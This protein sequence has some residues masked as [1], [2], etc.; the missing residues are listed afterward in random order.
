MDLS[1]EANRQ[2][3][4][5]FIRKE[6]RRVLGL[7]I[8]LVV[9]VLILLNAIRIAPRVLANGVPLPILVLGV[10]VDLVMAFGTL[11]LLRKTYKKLRSR[12]ESSNQAGRGNLDG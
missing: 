10:L 2:P 3:D 1:N 4:N 5:S 8:G 11:A 6:R 12:D 7:W 9:W